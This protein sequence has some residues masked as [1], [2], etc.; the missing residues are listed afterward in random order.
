MNT[1]ALAELGESVYYGNTLLAWAQAIV[2]FALWFTVLPIARGFVARRVAKRAADR[3]VN[4]LL[5][6]RSVTDVF[7]AGAQALG[8]A[9]VVLAPVAVVLLLLPPVGRYRVARH[10]S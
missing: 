2:T 10:R 8:V 9:A 7:P 5:M 4:A 3:P 1:E 6:L